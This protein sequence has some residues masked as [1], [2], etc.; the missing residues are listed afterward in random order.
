L[1]QRGFDGLDG[2]VDTGEA[3]TQTNGCAFTQRPWPD[4]AFGVISGLTGPF[5]SAPVPIAQAAD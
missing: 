3:E 2:A 4:V 1:L 5:Q